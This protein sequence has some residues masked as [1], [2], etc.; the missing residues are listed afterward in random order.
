[1]GAVVG[2]AASE[3]R[4]F[5]PVPLAGACGYATAV[6]HTYTLGSFL[7]PLQQEFGW[8]RA[9]ASI[10]MI[11]SGMTGATLSIPIGML[12]DRLGP[13]VVGLIGA[14]LMAMAFAL[15]GTA[16]GGTLN[17][18]LLWAFFAFANLWVQA[19]VWVSAVASRF[20]VSRGLALAVTMSG[21]SIGATVFPVF[22]TAMIEAFGWRMAYPVIAGLWLML[23]FPLMFL[24]FRG[25]QDEGR[26]ERTAAHQAADDL[27]GLSVAEGLRTSA[28]YKLLLACCL[29]TL[30]VVGTVIHFVP[31]LR[32]RGA[33]PLVAATIAGLV[34][35]TS[36]GGRLGTGFLLD[37]LP[38]RIVGAIV[39]TLPILG[40]ALLLL[41]GADRLTQSAAAMILGFSLG[42]EVDVIAYLMSRHLGLKRAGVFIGGMVSALSLGSA[43]GPYVAAAIHDAYASY[44]PFLALSMVCAAVSGLAVATLGRPRFPVQRHVEL[45]GER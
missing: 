30:T 27:P 22:S 32:D 34:G 14:V 44:S 42:A 29:F 16:T 7:L 38:A 1:M 28:F 10:G 25:A 13:R 8:S 18:L 40:W 45:A 4:R 19:T 17:W 43:F 26:K 6:I 21:G 2:T 12:I 36:I 33:D 20:E 9:F 23:V 24:W 37:R 41:N 11:V 5:W 39:L 15:F 35:I 3:W 31:I